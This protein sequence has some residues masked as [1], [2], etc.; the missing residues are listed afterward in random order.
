[1]KNVVIT[2]ISRG[3]GKALAE[4]FLSE[5]YS[6][7]GTSTSGKIDFSHDNLSVLKL[8]LSKLESIKKCVEEIGKLNKKIDILINNAGIVVEEEVDTKRIDIDYLK[9]TLEV[10]LFGTIEFTEQI[11][12]YFNEGGHIVSISSR[13]GS[14]E[15]VDYT[16]N[17]PSYRISKT[18]L[19]MVTRILAVRLDGKI[20]VSSVH[21]GWVKTDM[22]G[23]EADIESGE[24]AEDIFNLSTSSVET[25]Q[26]WFKG[27]R[28]PW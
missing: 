18:A 14:L 7:I 21:P 16:L 25:G 27:K 3:I 9:E 6:V 2:G 10:N 4:K 12:P 24:A 28:F 20:T 19:N 5:G 26:F 15:H 1:M 22:G 23:D 13:A 8:D 17:Y 11:I